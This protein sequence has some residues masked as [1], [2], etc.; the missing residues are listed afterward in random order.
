M[1]PAKAFLFK[2]TCL[3]AILIMNMYDGIQRE[4][5]IEA[6]NDLQ[7]QT[8]AA[9]LLSKYFDELKLA[10]IDSDA[11]VMGLHSF[12]IS[13]NMEFRKNI[14]L[15]DEFF[16]TLLGVELLGTFKDEIVELALHSCLRLLVGQYEYFNLNLKNSSL[17]AKS[18]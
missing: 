11:F 16:Q 8:R 18:S 3:L 13:M 17:S 9:R 1:I 5:A 7:D 2:E 15:Q 10:V 6:I 14:R 4:V 12:Y